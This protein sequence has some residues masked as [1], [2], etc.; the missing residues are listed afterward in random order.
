MC[1]TAIINPLPKALAQSYIDQLPRPRPC[2]RKVLSSIED[3]DT[4]QLTSFRVTNATDFVK[5]REHCLFDIEKG[6]KKL[7][8]NR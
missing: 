8:A 4:P 7:E 5:L 2:F 3:K 6:K 1:K